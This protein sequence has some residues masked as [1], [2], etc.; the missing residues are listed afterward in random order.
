[1]NDNELFEQARRRVQ[2]KI[3]GRCVTNKDVIVDQ[4]RE[5]EYYRNKIEKIIEKSYK[6]NV[7]DN[8]FEITI[9]DEEYLIE[10]NND[11]EINTIELNAQLAKL[12]NEKDK[13]YILK[14]NEFRILNRTRYNKKTF[15]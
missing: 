7:F 10:Y 3:K 15:D 13:I 6:R 12:I 5:I 9:N 2:K 1:M 4:E 8:R 11:K 14:Y